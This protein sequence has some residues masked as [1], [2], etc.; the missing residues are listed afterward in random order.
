MHGTGRSQYNS[1]WGVPYW[2][3]SLRRRHQGICRCHD[4]LQR[5]EDTA[6]RDAATVAKNLISNFSKS[7]LWALNGRIAAISRCECALEFVF[8]KTES[9]IVRKYYCCQQ[10]SH[11]YLST[12][13]I[14]CKNNKKNIFYL[15]DFS[16]YPAVLRQATYGTIKFG[17]YY[18]L[19]RLLGQR[20]EEDIFINVSCAVVA[21]SVSSTIANPTDV[22][23]VR[24]QVLGA[25]TNTILGSFQDVYRHEGVSG[26]WRVSIGKIFYVGGLQGNSWHL[27]FVQVI[28]LRVHK[29]LYPC[30][31][32]KLFKGDLF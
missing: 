24:M 15:A 9:P 30:K 27:T 11:R 17:T 10:A 18:S 19:K 8:T 2:F 22:L 20:N 25:Q 16:I 14:N 12:W 7:S 4:V 5:H 3:V 13:V 31:G 28:H 32:K 6:R 26:L 21:G 23:K 1:C 29:S